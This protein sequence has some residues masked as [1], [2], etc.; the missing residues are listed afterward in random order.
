MCIRDRSNN[1]SITVNGLPIQNFKVYNTREERSQR[2]VITSVSECYRGVNLSL[3][4]ISPAS[5]TAGQTDADAIP[6]SWDEPSAEISF[7][8]PEEPAPQ[9]V[10]AVSYTHLARCWS[11][12]SAARRRRDW[13]T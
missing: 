7:S 5:V 3:I 8:I 10:A 13:H 4:H 9:P 2:P 6:L 1:G 11:V 12:L